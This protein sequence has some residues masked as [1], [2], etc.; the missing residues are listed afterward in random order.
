MLRID[1]ST[2]MM[3]ACPI[4]TSNKRMGSRNRSEESAPASLAGS[5]LRRMIGQSVLIGNFSRGSP[6]LVG[7]DEID[8]EIQRCETLLDENLW[9]DIDILS[10]QE[11]TL[12]AEFLIHLAEL[13]RRDVCT[14][15]GFS[16][17][18]AY[19][20]RG[21][22]HS[23]F[24]AIMRIKAARAACRFPSIY[25]MLRASEIH[26]TAVAMLEPFLNSEN[27]RKLL[28]RA[29]GRRKHELE[30]LV[31]Q[32]R[33][34]AP[35]PCD[36]IRALPAPAKAP[37]LTTGTKVEPALEL[38]PRPASAAP[39]ASPPVSNEDSNPS[40]PPSPPALGDKDAAR[41]GRK[42]FTFAGS[43]E[44]YEWFLQ[45]RDLLRHRFPEG[46]MEDIVGEALRR[47]VEAESPGRRKQRRAEKRAEGSTPAPP[48][49]GASLAATGRAD[50]STPTLPTP[51]ASARLAADRALSQ[52]SAA[53]G[54]CQ[55]ATDPQPRRIPRWVQDVVWRRDAGRCS[56]MGQTG[57]RCGETAWL[58]FDHIVPWARGGHSDDPSN[59]RLLCRAH[60]QAEARRAFPGSY[61]KLPPGA[62][63]I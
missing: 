50:G 31:A 30:Q 11:R 17:V 46:R 41:S 51:L 36:R 62:A 45:A 9:K 61:P 55:G 18:F 4:M 39:D 54:S 1:A 59:V 3:P 48:R 49:P 10:R 44:V 16:S 20:T 63:S 7:M 8:K 21:L 13:D 29:Q 22:G 57:I 33:P 34:A 56:Y 6:V 53:S 12:L 2:P 28:G 24:E 43:M 27:H 5:L 35:E 26:M 32:L 19:L 42:L 25:R 40:E 58:E 15:Y 38:L 52:G 37:Q 60:N 47:L 23:E 14:R